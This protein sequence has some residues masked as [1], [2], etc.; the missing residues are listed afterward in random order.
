MNHIEILHYSLTLGFITLL[1]LLVYFRRLQRR[2]PFFVAYS[3]ILL[4]C[5]VGVAVF[6]HHFGF[7]SVAAFNAYWI[8]VGVVVIARTIAIAELC[9][10]E[11]RAYHGI[12][13]L[14]WRILALLAVFFL[15][16]AAADAWGQTGGIA[17]YGLTI[18]RDMAVSSIAILLALLLIRR[19]Y[20]LTLQPLHMWIA[21]GMLIVSIIETINTAV[22]RDTFTGHLIFWFFGRYGTN[23]PGLRPQVES[24][25]ELWNR[26]HTFGEIISICIW[27]FALRKPLPAPAKDPV[28]L[29][30]EIYNE[31]SPAVNLRLR[32]FNNRLLGMLKS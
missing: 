10:Y 28:L 31:V 12:W 26:I 18:E 21:T 11:L 8:A 3:T 1:C 23:W 30:A 17:I 15:V 20:G 32:A 7:R 4:V 22:L 27:C 14:T 5:T 13:A 16:H 24:A 19:Y 2:L 6:Y 29:P 9:R 25:T